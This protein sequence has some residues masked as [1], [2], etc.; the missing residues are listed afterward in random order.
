MESNDSVVQNPTF[1]YSTPGKHTVKL[2]VTD[3]AGNISTKIK[4]DYIEVDQDS[5]GDGIVDADDNCPLVY[6]PDQRDWDQ[7]GIGDACDNYT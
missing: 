7:D 1:V 4:I 2:T 3:S 6:N 5:D